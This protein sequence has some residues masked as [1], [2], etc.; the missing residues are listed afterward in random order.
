MYDFD[1]CIWLCPD[2][3]SVWNTYTRG[4]TPH[5]TIHKYLYKQA[6]CDRMTELKK[7]EF[8]L[9]VKLKGELEIANIEDFNAL[10]NP[11]ELVDGK[12]PYW[13]P[14]DAHVSFAYQYDLEFTEKERRELEKKLIERETVFTHFKL[15][16]CNGHYKNWK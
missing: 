7:G 10:E 1:Y 15:V 3:D 11:V 2:K 9:K 13:W 4:F 16:K 12:E 14:E 8:K 5:I 6:A